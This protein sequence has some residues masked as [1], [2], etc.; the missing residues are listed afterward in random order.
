MENDFDRKAIIVK[1]TFEYEIKA[2]SNY[3]DSMIEWC[4]P[5]CKGERLREKSDA[6]NLLGESQ[7][8]VDSSFVVD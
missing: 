8:V 3:C 1:R 4:D 2:T 7:S 5:K 6:T